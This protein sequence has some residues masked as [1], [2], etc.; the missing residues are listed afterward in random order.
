M[1]EIKIEQITLFITSAR[2]ISGG[3]HVLMPQ[4]IMEFQTIFF[5]EFHPFFFVWVFLLIMVVDVDEKERDYKSVRKIKFWLFIDIFI[6]KM[7]TVLNFAT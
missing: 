7:M 4:V 1:G 6:F 5:V 2:L 3:S